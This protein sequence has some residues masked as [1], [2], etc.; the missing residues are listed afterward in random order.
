MMDIGDTIITTSG[1]PTLSPDTGPCGAPQNTL[2]TCIK[3]HG[4][5]Q[6]LS[7]SCHLH[8]TT[9]RGNLDLFVLFTAL[10]QH[11]ANDWP[12]VQFN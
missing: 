9:L 3:R 8:C 6:F 2:H 12:R 4:P 1:K 5:Q 10:P 7:Y 11:L